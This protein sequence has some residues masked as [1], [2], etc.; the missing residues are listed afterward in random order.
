M[1]GWYCC[2]SDPVAIESSELLFLGASGVDDAPL[3]GCELTRHDAEKLWHR[4]ATCGLGTNNL[5]RQRKN[6]GSS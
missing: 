4:A 3:M 5:K 6:E 2:H 1:T